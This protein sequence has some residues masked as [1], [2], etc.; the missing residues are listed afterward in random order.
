VGGG[1]ATGQISKSETGVEVEAQT[2]DALVASGQPV[3]D[4]IKV[5][6]EGWEGAA[7]SGAAKV[8]RERRPTLLVEL[9]TPEQDVVV[10]AILRDLNYSVERLRPRER[11]ERLDRGWP[12]KQGMWGTVVAVA[13]G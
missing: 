10:G 5:D 1:T 13:R 7:L 6:V 3:P 8:L 4:F 12:D 9:H 11:V 2:I